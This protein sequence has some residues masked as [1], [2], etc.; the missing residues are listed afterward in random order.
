MLSITKG[1][2]DGVLLTLLLLNFIIAK[3]KKQ[4]ENRNGG[5]SLNDIRFFI[6]FFDAKNYDIMT[7][8]EKREV[9]EEEATC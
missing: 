2:G 4:R 6:F 1:K 9:D 7:K 5:K 8:K 3:A